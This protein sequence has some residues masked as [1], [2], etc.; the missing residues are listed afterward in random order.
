MAFGKAGVEITGRHRL[1]RTKRP[2]SHTHNTNKQPIKDREKANKTK[3]I[4][5]IEKSSQK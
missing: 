4:Q 5:E 1:S 2:E 3:N